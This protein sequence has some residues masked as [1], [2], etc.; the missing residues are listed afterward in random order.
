VT[1]TAVEAYSG[2]GKSHP[3]DSESLKKGK[4]DED[5]KNLMRGEIMKIL[6]RGQ[7]VKK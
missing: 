6:T 1:G 5:G 2:N 7:I 4:V 3:R